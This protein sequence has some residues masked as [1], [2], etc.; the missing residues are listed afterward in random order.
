M[1]GKRTRTAE[2]RSSPLAP[3]RSVLVAH[4]LR[5]ESDRVLTRV[6]R[7]PLAP[8]VRLAL[9]HTVPKLLPPDARRRATGDA[10]EA[11]EKI[12][13]RLSRTLPHG[14]VVQTI[15]SSGSAAAEIRRQTKKLR[16]ELVIVGRGRPHPLR[17][18]V[19]GSTAEQVVRQ[20]HLP[21][22]LVRRTARAL[23]RQPLLALDFDESVPDALTMALR[24]LTVPRPSLRL[25]HAVEEPFD[26]RAYPSVTAAEAKRY[27]EA[28]RRRSLG[29][30]AET[31]TLTLAELQAEGAAEDGSTTKLAWPISVRYGSPRVVIERE[32]RR[33]GADLLV[34]GSH[35][36]S[37]LSEA[38]LGTVSGDVL[39]SVQCDVLV[40][41]ARAREA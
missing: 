28:Y 31:V 20:A 27:R 38:V 30:L 32:V 34:L 33:V 35:E 1:V 39:R 24:L 8:D 40:V 4:A 15:V 26:G 21:V 7:L 36:Q 25:L 3:L 29:K 23:Y 14:A 6:E 18:E 13:S 11:L 10:R 5:P 12:A 22:L 2:R 37:A 17:D 19:L 16:S 41:P 9:L